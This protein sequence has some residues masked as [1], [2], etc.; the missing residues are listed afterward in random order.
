[1]FL[2]CSFLP[3]A[4]CL[5]PL[6]LPELEDPILPATEASMSDVGSGKWILWGDKKTPNFGHSWCRN[7][8]SMIPP[9]VAD[10]YIGVFRSLRI[11]P[12]AFLVFVALGPVPFG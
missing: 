12:L 3:I 7:K 8:C 11:V 5:P 4:S 2:S 9:K 1:M 6:L 10:R